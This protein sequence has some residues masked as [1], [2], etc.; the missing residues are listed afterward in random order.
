MMKDCFYCGNRAMGVDHVPPRS[1][2]PKEKDLPP[3]V[4]AVRKN[5][6]TVPAC[7]AHN[8]RYSVDDEIASLVVRLPYQ[9]NALGQRDFLKKGFR[10]I[11][12]SRGLVRSLFP[13]IE[14]LQFPWGPRAAD[15]GIRC[16][17]RESRYGTYRS[18]TVLPRLR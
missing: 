15:L 16:R 12:N 17:A 9:A 11:E 10:A 1:F 14:V 3:A 6:I 8:G 18:R 4:A 2:F 13:R 7:D 5:L